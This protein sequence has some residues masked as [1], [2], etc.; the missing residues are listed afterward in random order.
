VDEHGSW[1]PS[2][3]RQRELR[4]VRRSPARVR[5]RSADAACFAVAGP[6]FNG[7][8]EITNLGWSM[9]E[10]ALARAFAIRTSRSSMIFAVALGVP[11][12]A[13]TM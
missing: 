9:E 8:A 1:W 6:V 4:N 12:S 3:I 13:S 2:A 11:L 5:Q 7:R 10:E